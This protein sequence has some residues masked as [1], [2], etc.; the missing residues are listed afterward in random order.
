MTSPRIRALRALRTSAA[1]LGLGVALLATALAVPLGTPP[2]VRAASPTALDN[3][4]TFHGRGYGHGVGM[5]QY[6]ARGRAIAGQTAAQILGHY[7]AGTTLGS[8]DP[9]RTIRVLL[10]TDFS[11]TASRPF[12]IYGRGGTWRI[13]ATTGDMPADAV[14]EM[15]RV[16]IAPGS[17]TLTWRTTIRAA[18]GSVLFSRDGFTD[19]TLDRTSPDTRLELSAKGSTYD[20]YRGSLRVRATSTLR[21]LNTVSLTAYVLGVLPAEMPSTWPK[22]AL[23]AQAIASR[24]FA[25]HAIRT[26]GDFDV[27]DDTRS[28]VYRGSVAEKA[29]TTAAVSGTG[30]SVVMSGS[31]IAQT[32]YHSTG[33]GWTE[34]N[35]KAWVGSSGQKVAAPVS[36]LRGSSDRRPDGT[37]YDDSSPYAVWQT[38]TYTK[39]ALSKIFDA[40][41]RTDVGSLSALDLSARGVSGRL[42]SVTLVGSTGS[43]KVS[44]EVF[45]SVFNA[46]RPAGDGPMWST[47]FN[48]API[49]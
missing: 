39:A 13:R 11:P 14:L 29:T 7:F 12:R 16:P 32:F 40:D 19:L 23:R 26:T 49:P 20:Q 41:D 48:V 33:G 37:S 6:G 30:G 45:R 25:A 4:T 8:I 9:A 46:H 5:N 28:Q 18:G 17:S 47:L 44:G 15:T 43:K 1:R 38:K 24:S 2:A 42:M 22:E 35:E 31:L 21:V 36:Y 10:M 27:Y 3:S 34:D